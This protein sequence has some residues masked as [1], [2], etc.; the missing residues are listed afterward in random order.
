MI[1]AW[2]T[3]Y[4]NAKSNNRILCINICKYFFTI[5]TILSCKFSGSH[6]I[7]FSASLIYF[8]CVDSL[9]TVIEQFTFRYFAS[10]K[11]LFYFGSL[12]YIQSFGFQFQC[13]LSNCL[14]IYYK[15]G[16]AI[17]FRATRNYYKKPCVVRKRWRL[18]YLVINNNKLQRH[19]LDKI[20]CICKRFHDVLPYVIYSSTTYYG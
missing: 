12:K 11:Y 6:L 8:C 5:F 2:C 18:K 16:I 15:L 14:F 3:I 20:Y 4:R 7:K 19:F 10:P 13:K 1:I 17:Y 9:Y